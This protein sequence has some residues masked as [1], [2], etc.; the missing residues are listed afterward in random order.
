MG[1]L[2]IV[3]GVLAIIYPLFATVFT[4]NVIGFVL[5]LFGFLQ[6][7]HGFQLSKARLG[8]HLLTSLIGIFYLM[9]GFW[10][11]RHPVFS[12]LD[13]TLVIGILFVI[14]GSVQVIHAFEGREEHRKWPLL[15]GI[16]GIILGILIWSRW[17]LDSLTLLGL[18]VGINLI[19][20]GVS[21]VVIFKNAK[22]SLAAAGDLK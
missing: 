2:M 5:L 1:V 13:L 9:V 19:M 18:L 20:T 4:F 6:L 16:A 17:P 12:I 8:Q 10:I 22:Q 15:N 11:L 14:Q 3:L 21:L 7:F